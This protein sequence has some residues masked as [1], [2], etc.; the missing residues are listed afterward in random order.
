MAKLSLRINMYKIGLIGGA[1]EIG[2]SMIYIEYNKTAIV[3]DCGM[4]FPDDLS[5]F[6]VNR[7]VSFGSYIKNNLSKVKGLFIT[8]MHEDHIGGIRRFLEKFNVPIY[9]ESLTCEFLKL[10]HAFKESTPLIPIKNNELIQMGPITIRP[11]EVEHSTIKAFGYEIISKY[12]NIVLTGDF[13]LGNSLVD[14]ME[15]IKKWGIKESPLALLVES[16]NANKEGFCLHESDIIDNIE[17]LVRKH[18]DDLLIISTFASNM[19]RLKN[20][21]DVAQRNTQDIFV[22]GRNMEIAVSFLIQQQLVPKSRINFLNDDSKGSVPDNALILSTGCQGETQGGLY[23]LMEKLKDKENKYVLFS[24]SVIP[25]NERSVNNLKISLL[26][27]NFKYIEGADLYH[28]SGHGRKEEIKCLI[29]SLKPKYVIPV[30]GDYIQQVANK[31]NAITCG[32]EENNIILTENNSV[33]KLKKDRY[34]V[35]NIIDG[36]EY[37]TNNGIVKESLIE[38]KKVMARNGV[39]IYSI[40]G[41]YIKYSSIG[42]PDN[43]K[44]N[45]IG[46]TFVQTFLQSFNGST[47]DKKH[48]KEECEA[49]LIEELKNENNLPYIEVVMVENKTK[50][51]TKKTQPKKNIKKKTKTA[52]ATKTDVKIKSNN[53][54]KKDDKTKDKQ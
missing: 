28:T 36:L 15:N 53:Q 14:T 48:F 13:K 11:F 18:K 47:V 12:G 42:I 24:S 23:K 7:I 22:I 2:R 29:T 1:D 3:V 54:T 44:L 9:A 32:I 27:N 51:A 39:F 37:I 8:H 40:N 4:E 35:D 20:I 52:V 38:T 34:E 6:G 16:T 19:T 30:H 45:R 25:G 17:T 49:Y 10:K 31:E 50:T 41:R 43:C 21:I 5:M 33:L 46:R 26:K